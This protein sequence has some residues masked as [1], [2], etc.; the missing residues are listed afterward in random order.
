MALGLVLMALPAPAFSQTAYTGSPSQ[1]PLEMG[2]IT[3][4]GSSPFSSNMMSGAGQAIVGFSVN[5]VAGSASRIMGK[6]D[7]AARDG[8]INYPRRAH[9]SADCS[10]VLAWDPS[11][12]LPKKPLSQMTGAEE[13]MVRN[14][15]ILTGKSAP[16]Y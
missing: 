10:L 12:A 3:S 5:V 11:W 9:N 7:G 16:A 15:I 8:C 4:I 2:P 1:S 14:Y 6:N 13:N